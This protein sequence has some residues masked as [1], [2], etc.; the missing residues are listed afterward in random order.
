MKTISLALFFFAATLSA[1]IRKDYDTLLVPIAVK[2]LSGALG[3]R[4]TSTLFVENSAD[5][6]AR[7]PVFGTG[8]VCIT[9][10]CEYEVP[11]RTFQEVPLDFST[12]ETLPSVILYTPKS[13]RG[14]LHFNLRI[15]DLSRQSETWGTELPLVRDASFR[16]GSITLIGVPLGS[17]FRSALRVYDPDARA[18][19]EG[20]IPPKVHIVL[21]DAQSDAKLSEVD[22]D[23]QGPTSGTI[24]FPSRPGLLQV[25]DLSRL[26]APGASTMINVVV[27]PVTPQLR[28]WA[29]VSVTNN[30][31]QHVTTITPQ[32]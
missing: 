1:Q 5:T 28:I 31:T 14:E 17:T 30:T 8:I 21:R 32:E 16:T 13:H 18:A 19:G 2:D 10:P 9:A 15:R 4:W 27:T 3:S 25:G 23:V 20:T 12:D 26:I 24:D 6:P 11:P 7:L 29:F 22:L